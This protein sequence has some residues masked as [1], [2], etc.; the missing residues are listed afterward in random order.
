TRL[1]ARELGVSRLVA[2][3]AYEELA[4]AGYLYSVTGAGTF[5]QWTERGASSAAKAMPV[6][7]R[8]EGHTSAGLSPSVC[9]HPIVSQ[10]FEIDHPP[11]DAVPI[12]TWSRIASRCCM[13]HM[14]DVLAD[15]DPAGYG[16]F[17]QAIADHLLDTRG[18]HCD[19]DRVVVVSG[20]IQALDLTAR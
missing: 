8:D 13:R 16:P 7:A 12:K 9:M 15:N 5:V 1:V 19:A 2:V 14:R 10:A 3:T 20:L 4:T 18:L 17:R 6:R 11:P